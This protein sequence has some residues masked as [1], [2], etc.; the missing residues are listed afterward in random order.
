MIGEM[1][2]F[3]KHTHLKKTL[4]HSWNITIVILQK[5]KNLRS[6]QYIFLVL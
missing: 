2:Y 1:Y 6:A 5:K 4:F 3:Y